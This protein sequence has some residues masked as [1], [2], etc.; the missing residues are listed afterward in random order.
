MNVSHKS[1]SLLLA[2]IV[3]I[4]HK[5]GFPRS[6]TPPQP[7]IDIPYK[8]I[9]YIN[10]S[11]GAD[12]FNILTPHNDSGCYLYD[13]YLRERGGHNGI[14]LTL[15]EI[16]PINGKSAGIVGCNTF[17][18]NKLISVYKEIYDEGKGIFLAN[19][20]HLHK[21]VTKENWIRETRTDLFSHHTMTKESHQVDAFREGAGPGVLG[22]M[23]D[24]L[25]GYGLAVSS[26]ALDRKSLM[27]DGDP[28]TGR[29]ADV[30]SNTGPQL[31]YERKFLNRKAKREDLRGYIESRH[32]ETEENSGVLAN[33]QSKSFIY[34]WCGIF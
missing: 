9:I 1:A 22:R 13:E 4:V 27:V 12:S 3:S 8:A 15:E 23:L 6:L 26:T 21:P 16:L 11:G 10:L 31:I 34:T 2:A 28:S 14:G 24:E 5:T 18:V 7:K 20:G 17:G 33:I 29:L 25:A 32:Y 30:I 19:M